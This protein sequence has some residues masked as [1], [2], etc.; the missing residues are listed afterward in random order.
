MQSFELLHLYS[1]LMLQ[2]QYYTINICCE[3]LEKTVQRQV[4]VVD[5]L[6]RVSQ[7]IGQLLALGVFGQPLREHN[8][9]EHVADWLHE[10]FV[11]VQRLVRVLLQFVQQFAQLA[12][13]DNLGALTSHPE[14]L[15][16]MNREL[17]LLSP[18][19]AFRS[20]QS[21]TQTQKELSC[22]CSVRPHPSRVL[23]NMYTL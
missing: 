16:S 13:D 15:K 21:Y 18:P 7:F 20:D 17:A 10:D 1:I 9:E 14:L 19:T 12:L 8:G 4:L 23:E 2:L 5:R 22:C 11:R 6:V 3:P